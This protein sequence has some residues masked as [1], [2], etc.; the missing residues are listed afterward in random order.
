MDEE[1]PE[2]EEPEE[3]MKS[4]LLADPSESRLKPITDDNKVKG[5]A[6]AWTVRTY[7]DESV[8]SPANPTGA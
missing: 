7:G 6:P 5:N 4:R 1:A 2:G 8:Y 3:F